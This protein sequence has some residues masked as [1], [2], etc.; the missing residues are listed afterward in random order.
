MSKLQKGDVMVS[1]MT[2][3]GQVTV[4][5]SIRDE[6]DLQEGSLLQFQARGHQIIVTP[7]ELRPRGKR[8]RLK[9]GK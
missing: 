1:R 8:K 5:G 2:R 3:S 7:V 9:R 6:F 4:P